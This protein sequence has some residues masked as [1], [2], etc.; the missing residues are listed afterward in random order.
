MKEIL[1]DCSS[2]GRVVRSYTRH[3]CTLWTELRGGTVEGAKLN[4]E[5][6]LIW[7]SNGMMNAL[8]IWLPRLSED[9]DAEV[10]R[11]EG[12]ADT[13]GITDVTWMVDSE[14]EPKNL[15]DRLI[16]RGYQSFMNWPIL[17]MEIDSLGEASGPAGF[18]IERVED[19]D[20][21]KAWIG[22]IKATYYPHYQ[23]M[24]DDMFNSESAL[25]PGDHPVRR[26]LGYMHGEPVASSYLLM[27]HGVAGLHNVCTIPSMGRRGI[28]TAMSLHPLK[29]AAT[30]GYRV[31]AL[32]A[33]E[34]GVKVYRKI[35]FEIYGGL[36]ALRKSM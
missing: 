32:H 16:A 15:K 21:L 28:G 29:E 34:M 4:I 27:A 10:E 30:E 19:L 33:M 12:H 3:L 24:F 1:R 14:A 17:A 6:E 25:L 23:E 2:P 26:Y 5:E 31:A 22:V 7:A 35:G 18:T 8:D 13:M 36:T 11:M 9:V 20:D